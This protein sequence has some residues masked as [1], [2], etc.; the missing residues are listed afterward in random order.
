MLDTKQ[1]K[2]YLYIMADEEYYAEISDLDFDDIARDDVSEDDEDEDG[3]VKC[4]PPTHAGGGVEKSKRITTRYMTK[5]ERARVLGEY[6]FSQLS[7][8]LY[9]SF[10]F[11][12]LSF[13][14]LF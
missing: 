5:Y 10:M 14:Y 7:S 13:K 9:Y 12:K 2:P 1:E 4:L 8:L 11:C 6:H 3:N